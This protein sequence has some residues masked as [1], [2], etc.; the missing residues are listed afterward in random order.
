MKRKCP[1]GFGECKVLELLVEG[2]GF[3][4]REVSSRKHFITSE[5]GDIY[6]GKVLC[7][8]PHRCVEKYF[9]GKWFNESEVL[10]IQKSKSNYVVSKQYEGLN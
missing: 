5:K 4:L 3:N 8:N 1:E 6:K 9:D 2:E 7:E 10:E